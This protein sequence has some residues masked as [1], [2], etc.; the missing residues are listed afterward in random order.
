MGIS[1]LGSI[2]IAGLLATLTLVPSSGSGAELLLPHHPGWARVF[3]VNWEVGERNGESTVKGYLQNASPYTLDRIQL[4]LDALDTTGAVVA[5]KAFW[6]AGSQLEPFTR[7]Y[8][9]VTVPAPAPE[10]RVSV[11]SYDSMEAP[12]KR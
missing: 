7:R 2:L 11:Y 12:N 5:Q 6:L 4:I 1:R 9:E 8:F 3:K 10:Y